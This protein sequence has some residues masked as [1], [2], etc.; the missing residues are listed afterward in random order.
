MGASG[1]VGSR[2]ADRLL[3][4]KKDVRVFGRSAERLDGLARQGAEVLEGD[5]I[6][7]DDLHTLFKGAES[8]FVVLP[9]NVTDPQYVANRSA[10]SRAIAEALRDE[11]VGHIVMASSLGAEHSAGVGQVVGL[12]ELEE[13]LNGLDANVLALR[14]AFHME[15]FLGSVPMIQQQ[16]MNGSAVKA[17]LK[18]PMV[19]CMDIA[20]CAAQRLLEPTFTGHTVETVL[21]PE[22]RTMTEATRALGNALG[23]PD[24]PY[25][26]F[27]PEGVKAALQGIG[28]SEEFASLLVES[29][30]AINEGRMTAGERT[31]ENTTPTTLEE[32]LKT[33]LE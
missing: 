27:P 16:K 31:P 19:A 8:A 7:P 32:F 22:D 17:E 2:V 25:V 13:L 33:T 21:G 3:A 5:A 14:A 1:N 4:E 28:W 24:V 26:E 30:L 10:M 11:G 18:F 29:Q 6:R 12:H 9:D 15:N 20:E 23:M